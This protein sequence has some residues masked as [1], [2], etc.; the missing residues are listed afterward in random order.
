MKMRC[1][2]VYLLKNNYKSTEELRYSIRSVVQNFP[3]RKIVFVGGKPDGIEPDIYIPDEQEGFT[4][5]ER[6][7]HS[8]KAAIRHDEL[9][10]DIW[11]F[12]DDFFVMDKIRDW[13]VCNYFG[14][15][16]EKRIRDLRQKVGGSSYAG[17]LDQMRG[18]LIGLG[19][20][21]LSF[22]LHVPFLINRAKALALFEERPNLRM[23][24]SF[25]GNY[26]EIDCKYMKDVKIYDVKNV[27]FDAP[28]LSTS[29]DS[30]K[31]GKVGEFMR[32]Y[33]PEP[34]EYEK[35]KDQRIREQVRERYDEEGNERYE[36]S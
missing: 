15:T 5:W 6:S 34:S 19:K 23:F 22:A 2:V 3:Y 26:Y 24:R 20:D 17:Y 28:F 27:D 1:D 29:D 33:F 30:F 35:S 14:G 12:N 8:L 4:K 25:Y 36:N 21:T 10:E 11:L 13:E 16:L 7:T 9:T 18:Q 32:R 31:R